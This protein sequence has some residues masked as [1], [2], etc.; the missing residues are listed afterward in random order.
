MWAGKSV[1]VSLT[2][3]AVAGLSRGIPARPS[4]LSAGTE[5]LSKNLLGE[6]NSK[7]IEVVFSNSNENFSCPF[8]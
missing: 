5:G 1:S 2:R 3:G 7:V 8:I 4:S 6:G